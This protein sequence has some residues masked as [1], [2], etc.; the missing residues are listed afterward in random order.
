MTFTLSQKFSLHITSLLLLQQST[1][2]HFVLERNQHSRPQGISGASL[3]KSFSAST[4]TTGGD[5]DWWSNQKLK[6]NGSIRPGVTQVS[7]SPEIWSCYMSRIWRDTL[8]I[9]IRSHAF[10][11]VIVLNIFCL[12]FKTSPH[13]LW[14]R[15]KLQR[16][17]APE[18]FSELWSFDRISVF[19]WTFPLL[20][21][22]NRKTQ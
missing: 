14:L 13:L 3:Q 20:T 19:V 2:T 5:G 4:W 21:M 17:E 9:N 11:V 1:W 12:C 10:F 6:Y 8:Q 22:T 7:G 18:M 15:R 16:C